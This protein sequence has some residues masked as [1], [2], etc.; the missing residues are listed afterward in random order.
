MAQYKRALVITDPNRHEAKDFLRLPFTVDML[1]YAK[2]TALDASL[3]AL[4]SHYPNLTPG[5]RAVTVGLLRSA[6][7]AVDAFRLAESINTT[8]LL[9]EEEVFLGS[10]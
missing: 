7:R 1:L 2:T 8:L 9:P 4:Q 10:K 5:Q 6:G 3:L